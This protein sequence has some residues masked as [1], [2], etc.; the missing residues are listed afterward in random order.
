MRSGR[1]ARMLHGEVDDATNEL[2]G[3]IVDA[4]VTVHARTG[5]GLYED[6]YHRCLAYELQK[7]G[8]RVESQ[9]QVPIVYDGHVF[10]KAFRLDLVVDDVVVVEVKSVAS[11][12]RVHFV[13]LLTY[14][15][16]S[17]RRV[18]LLVN[19]NVDRAHHGIRRV[20]APP[21]PSPCLRAS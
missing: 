16:L 14:L 3:S 6:V 10:P 21:A 19:F 20:V 1:I 5:P 7:R 18:G 4:I 8:H 13:Q 15:R 9:V 11:L 17:G 2:T 12:E